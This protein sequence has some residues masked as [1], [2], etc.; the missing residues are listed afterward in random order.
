MKIQLGN[1][2]ISTA[3]RLK[4][5]LIKYAHDSDNRYYRYTLAVYQCRILGI[6]IYRSSYSFRKLEQKLGI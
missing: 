4:K 2:T 3:G 6:C 5:K 1:I